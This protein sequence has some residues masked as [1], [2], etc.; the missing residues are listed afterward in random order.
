MLGSVDWGDANIKKDCIHGILKAEML[1]FNF[2]LSNIGYVFM[3]LGILY[4]KKRDY[5]W[6][7]ESDIY[8]RDVNINL[9]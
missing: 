1:F 3:L 8:D 7:A 4:N 5:N 2:D 9:I 6:N